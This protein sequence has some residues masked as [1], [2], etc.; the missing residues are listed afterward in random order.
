MNKQALKLV[1]LGIG[2]VSIV[3][4]LSIPVFAEEQHDGHKM[5]RVATNAA[6][7]AKHH[8][9]HEMR[10]KQ[11]DEALKAIDKAAKAVE[12]GNK[13]AALAEL[14]EAKKLMLACHKAMSEMCMGKIVNVRCP[15][16]GT[17]L[18]PSK[19]PAKLTKVYN[20]KK[21][22]FCCAGCPS[23]WDKLNDQQKQEKLDKAGAKK[24]MSKQQACGSGC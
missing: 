6:T 9:T 2:I 11:L 19:V 13:D 12:A 4:L 10:V 1:G 5:H 20:G 21:I 7:P 17:K 15:I 8:S 24:D 18:D 22:G 3:A 23:A 16:M 14:A